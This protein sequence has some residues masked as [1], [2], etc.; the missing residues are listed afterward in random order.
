[1]MNAGRRD[2]TDMSDEIT[3][4]D[5][6]RLI[7]EQGPPRP[8][9]ACPDDWDF[10]RHLLL[11]LNKEFGIDWRYDDEYQ[12]D[13]DAPAIARTL[14]KYYPGIVDPFAEWLE[15]TSIQGEDEVLTAHYPSLANAAADLKQRY[16]AFFSDLLL[17]RWPEAAHRNTSWQQLRALGLVVPDKFLDEF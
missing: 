12:F 13:R 7:L 10:R 17:L 16:V 5:C 2:N 8:E 9:D 15:Y 11:L 6:C 3:F 4:D 14:V 1:M